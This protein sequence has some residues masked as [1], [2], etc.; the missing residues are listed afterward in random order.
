MSI[1][2]VSSRAR[3]RRCCRGSIAFHPEGPDR[4]FVV[5]KGLARVFATVADGRQATVTFVHPKELAGGTAIV[6][7]PPNVQIQVVVKSTLVSS[8]MEN[9]RRL[10]TGELDVIAAF[11][12]HLAARVHASF[13]LIAVRSLGRSMDGW[14][15]TSSIG[16][17]SHS[18]WWAAWTSKR[19]VWT[20]PTPS[21]YRARR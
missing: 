20:L 2:G 3:R 18:C 21:A 13:S 14:P 16:H 5:Q 19:R 15:T 6:S 17:A 9:V 12:T 11:A 8:D 1:D 4:S 10:A 7:H